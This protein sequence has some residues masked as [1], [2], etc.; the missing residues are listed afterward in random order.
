MAHNINHTVTASSGIRISSARPNETVRF[1]LFGAQAIPSVML[2]QPDLD[3][4]KSHHVYWSCE[5]QKLLQT[6]KNNYSNSARMGYDRVEQ[7]RGSI[8]GR[9]RGE[10]LGK[11]AATVHPVAT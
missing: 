2:A 11:G 5:Q 8:G 9:V 10:F 1:R 3:Q 6:T 4:I 7:I